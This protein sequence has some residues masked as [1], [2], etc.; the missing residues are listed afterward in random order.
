MGLG[1][2]LEANWPKTIP[3]IEAV[4]LTHRGQSPRG[5]YQTEYTTTLTLDPNP[6]RTLAKNVVL[7][8]SGVVQGLPDGR[9]VVCGRAHRIPTIGYPV[10]ET[11]RECSISAESNCVC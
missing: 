3:L 7:V 6:G 2:C 4:R 1:N 10:E 8:S 11:T 9:S 5:P